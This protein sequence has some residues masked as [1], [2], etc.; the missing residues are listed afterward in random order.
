LNIRPV[1]VSVDATN[2]S[3]YTGGIFNNCAAAGTNHAVLAF[4][5]D[6]DSWLVKNSWGTT[7]GDNGF[8]RL[9]LGNTCAVT[10]KIYIAN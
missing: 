9:S 8:I 10:S 3:K 2:W 6:A 7:W 5:Y 1:A 4:G